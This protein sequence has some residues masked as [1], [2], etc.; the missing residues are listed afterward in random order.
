MPTPRIRTARRM[1]ANYKCGRIP[2]QLVK[3]AATELAYI[4]ATKSSFSVEGKEWEQIFARCVAGTWDRSNN[5]LEDVIKGQTAW[6]AKT[7]SATRKDIHSQEEVNLISGRNSTVFSFNAAIT[8]GSPA[9]DA[10][11]YV[12][13]IWNRRVQETKA[14]YKD[15]RT[16]VLVKGKAPQLSHFALFEIPT[17][18]YDANAYLYRWN[19]NG[20]LEIVSADTEKVKMKWQ[21][22]GSQFTIIETIPPETQFFYVDPPRQLTQ[23][24]V[25]DAVSFS[26]EC[27]HLER[28][29]RT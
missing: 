7:V 11:Q 22:T 25:L 21:P 14:A 8:Q 23:R 20:V 4:F 29:A 19:G 18:Q 2:R 15:F 27:I 6:S 13:D 12:L 9:R 3:S 1:G 26:N 24:Q 16:I 17:T 28:R 10:G 5:K